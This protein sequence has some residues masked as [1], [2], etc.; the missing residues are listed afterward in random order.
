MNSLFD[1]AKSESQVIPKKNICLFFC[2]INQKIEKSDQRQHYHF[3]T[4]T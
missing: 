2:N 3:I 1:H 4:V